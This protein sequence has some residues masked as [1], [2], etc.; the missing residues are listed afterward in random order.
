MAKIHPTAIIAD[1]AD[2]ADDVEVGPYSIVHD[3]VHVGAGTKIGAHSIIHS[4]VSLGESNMIADHVVLG[5]APQDVSYQGQETWLR[6]GNKNIIR[7]YS[8]I[9]RSN[10]SDEDTMMG[11]SCYMMCNSHVGHNCK[12]G[13]NVIITAYTGLSGHVEVGDKAVLGGSVAIHQFCRIGAYAMVAGF[14]PVVKDVMPYCL[15]GRDPV[16]HYKLNSIGL[17]RAGITGKKYK[18]LEKRIR[19][20]RT[21]DTDSVDEMTDEIRLL[22]SWMAA[23]SKRGIY[24]FI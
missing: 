13:N 12:I 20:I 24:K 14:T 22:E 4:Y 5:G 1:K 17:R 8:S 19:Q 16:A 15:L 3:D 18:A 23:P 10:C 2:L 21:G 6:I 7:E 11:N 9:H